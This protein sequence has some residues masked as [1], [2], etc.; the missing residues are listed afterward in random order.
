MARFLIEGGTPLMGE[1]RVSGSKNAALPILAAALLTEEPCV[2]HNVPDIADVRVMMDIARDLGA[3]LTFENNTVRMHTPSIATH[4]IDKEKAKMLRAGLMYSAPLLARAGEVKI[5]F[6]GGCN[7]GKRP[8]DAILNSLTDLGAQVHRADEL[9]HLSLRDWQPASTR[10]EALSVIGTEIALMA[11]AAADGKSEIRLAASEPHVQD[12]CAVLQKMGATI[13]GVGGNILSVTGTKKLRGFEHTVTSDYIELGTFVIASL[14]TKG[15][16]KI[17]HCDPT[18]LDM[19]WHWLDVMGARYE[20]GKDY[21]E[22]F[23]T[24]HLG[25]VKRVRS[26]VYPDFPT[27]LLA[28][29]AVLLTQAEGI[30]RIFETIYEARLNYIIELE[31][32]GVKAE[33]LNAHEAIIVGPAHLKGAPVASWDL[34]AGCAMVLAGLAAEG[35]TEVSQIVYIDRGYEAFDEKLRALGAKITRAPELHEMS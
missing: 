19:F 17:T 18:H 31:K 11:A 30:N 29:M 23:P 8:I 5:P 16:V 2:I 1:V 33:I 27:D 20:V 13:E 4:E 15:H 10:I 26:G 32:M 25:H 34:R 21:V 24:E 3:E 12:L 6:P 28:P 9:V 7:I 35:T 22:V 14:V